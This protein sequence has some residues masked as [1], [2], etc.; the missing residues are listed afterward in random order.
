MIIRCLQQPLKKTLEANVQ[1]STSTILSIFDELYN[2]DICHQL[3]RSSGFIQRSTSKIKGHEFLKVLTLPSN[4]LSEDSLNGLCERM[5]AF[6]PEADI[7]A[8]ALIQRIN[9][10]A[11]VRFIKDCFARIINLTRT[12]LKKQYQAIEGPLK[13]F[14]NIYIQD[15]TVFE[16][17]KNLAK[18]FPG[19]R[20]GGK[21]GGSSCKSQMKIDLVHNFATGEIA[22]VQLYEGKRPDQALSGKIEGLVT[23]GDLV[24]RDLGY[25]KTESFERLDKA[26][27]YFLSRFPSH[28][29]VYLNPADKKPIDLATY[30]NMYFKNRS[31]IDL[32]LWITDKR[33]EV[34]LVAYRV[35]K[36]I[37]TERKRKAHINSK[38][39]GRTL[40]KEKL[41]LLEFSLFVTNIPVDIVSV[42]VI[43]TIYRLRWEIELIFKTWKSHLKID[44]LDGICLHRIL[45]LVWSRLCMV[46]LVA[47]VTANFMNLANKLCEGELSQ[48]KL[49][50]YLLRNSVLCRAVETQTLEQLENRMIQNMSRRFMKDSR[51]RK[52]MREAIDQF[53]PYY[54]CAAYA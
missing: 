5:S 26:K 25:F 48:N 30:L 27:A 43:G 28:I 54:G 15:S 22:D 35:P 29:K 39:R 34:R 19:T 24:I 23:E 40:S 8:S 46:V 10:K 38:E 47:Y 1:H 18:F 6:N 3:A 53:E 13:Y 49:I 51:C 41:A 16:I 17:N 14:K 7:S 33:L 4:G 45:C 42:E 21:K 11:A 36:N 50:T 52:T 31:T 44:I 2:P 12:R 37:V 9:T 32:R 20:R